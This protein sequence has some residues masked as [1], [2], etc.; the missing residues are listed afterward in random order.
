MLWPGPRAGQ[1]LLLA[2][3]AHTLLAGRFSVTLDELSQL[4][5]PVLRHR[6]LVNFKGQAKVITANDVTRRLLAEVP[7]PESPL[8]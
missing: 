1:S 8:A 2:A 4:A 5:L 3:K 7:L 6:I